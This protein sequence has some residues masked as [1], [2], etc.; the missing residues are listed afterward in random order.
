VAP[1]RRAALALC[2]LVLVHAPLHAAILIHEYALRG[3]LNDNIGDSPLTSLGGQITALGYVFAAN[4]GLAFSSRT[5]T[6]ADYSIELSFKLDSTFAQTKLIDFHN[7]TSD[8]GVYQQAGA[9]GFTPIVTGPAND[10]SPGMNVHL[11]LT[12]DANT[13]IVSAYLNGQLR[14]SFVDS[15]GLASP[16]GFSNKFN[17]F[18]DEQLGAPGAGGTVNYLRIFNGALTANEVGAL[19][20]GGPPTAIP[21][22]SSVAL[23]GIGAVGLA[24]GLRRKRPC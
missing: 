16:P 21:E 8:P 11:V 15:Q 7:L 2:A 24:A 4:Q 3:S 14:F 6:P 13:N 1:L 18:V 22:P 19:F 20:S 5:L 12:R 10:L 23:F 9:L 17:F